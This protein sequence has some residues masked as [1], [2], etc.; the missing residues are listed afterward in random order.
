MIRFS[1]KIKDYTGPNPFSDSQARNFS[2]EKVIDE[3][4]PISKFWNLFNDQHEILLGTRGSGKTFLLK[5]MRYSMLKQISDPKA[6][7]LVKEKEFIS[8][9]VPMYL[10]FVASFSNSQFTKRNQVIFF[11]IGFNCKLSEALITELKSILDDIEDK[12]IRTEIMFSLVEYLNRVWFGESDPEIYDFS[13]LSSKIVE[14]FYNI[15]WDNIDLNEIP[16]VFKRQICSPLLV[17]KTMITKMLKLEK[18][19]TWIVCI[20]EA[21]FLNEELLKCINNIFRSDSNRIALKVATLPYYHRTLNTLV[22]NVT[23]ADGNDFSFRVVDLNYENVDFIALTNKLC[24]H[25]LQQRFNCQL[26]C[27]DLETF[28]GLIG[29]DDQIDY[30]RAEVGEENSQRKVI[31][32]KIISGCSPKRRE[33]AKNYSNKRKTIYDKYAPILFMREM[34]ELSKTGNHKPGW[35]AGAKNVRK[36]SQGNPRIYIQIMNDL[37]EKARK[38]PLSPKVQHE[39]IMKF[40]KRFC[41]ETQALEKKGPVIYKELKKISSY[42]Q[43]KVHSGYLKTTG[44]SFFLKYSEE[45]EFKKSR[46]WLE[47][48]IAYS[49]ITVDDEIK[50]CGIKHDTKFML[51]NIYAMAYWLP[52]RSDSPENIVLSHMETNAYVVKAMKKTKPEW[53]QLSLFDEVQND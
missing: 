36:L 13:M 21:E 5:M 9:Y 27:P 14:M 48:A 33:N 44:I 45:T 38:T 11:Q 25:R 28:L 1:D 15:E 8:I 41:D 34:Y 53:T 10:E 32:D 19:P 31:E 3:F 12:T 47:L 16:A 52:I 18:E 20:D 26:N 37:F 2:D 7:K 49:R 35:F 17:S 42:L 51:S 6:E 50:I 39:V 29:N 23:V 46:E 30:Y 24:K 22:T 40:S 4:Y 43:D